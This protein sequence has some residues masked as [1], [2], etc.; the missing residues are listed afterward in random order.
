MI[1]CRC[2]HCATFRWE[3]SG[4]PIGV[5]LPE[6]SKTI[7]KCSSGKTFRLIGLRSA[8]WFVIEEIKS[9]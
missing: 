3:G 2:F 9:R 1:S 4:L 6:S 7:H 8:R 5:E